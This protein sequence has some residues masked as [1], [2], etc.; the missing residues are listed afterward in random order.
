[1]PRSKTYSDRT[2]IC[3]VLNKDEEIAIKERAHGKGS[4]LSRYVRSLILN[5][6]KAA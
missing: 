3:I 4:D 1:M 2:R 6:L 5:D